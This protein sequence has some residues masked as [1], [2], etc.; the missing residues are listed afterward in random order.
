MQL[1]QEDVLAYVNKVF[2][3]PTLYKRLCAV[4]FLPKK[5]HQSLF[6][7][8]SRTDGARKDVIFFPRHRTALGCNVTASYHHPTSKKLVKSRKDS[9]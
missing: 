1:L 3:F 7:E 4:D 2:S 6:L 5:A 8:S 9:H